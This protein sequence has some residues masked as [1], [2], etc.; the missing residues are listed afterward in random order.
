VLLDRVEKK[1][2]AFRK[3]RGCDGRSGCRGS[4]TCCWALW[5][6]KAVSRTLSLG[7]RGGEFFFVEFFVVRVTSAN[8]V[9][10]DRLVRKNL[11]SRFSNYVVAE[12]TMMSSPMLSDG[13]INERTY[14]S[15]GRLLRDIHLHRH[16]HS[17]DHG[18]EF[19]HHLGIINTRA[20]WRHDGG[21]VTS[22]KVCGETRLRCPGTMK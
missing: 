19:I 13:V 5:T 12:T 18:Q 14:M 4:S 8:C 7:W 11:I 10:V 6:S 3:C 9:C 20:L 22:I 2:D 15:C 17:S 21:W 1:V 16:W